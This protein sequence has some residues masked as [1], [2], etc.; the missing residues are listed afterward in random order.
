LAY[1]NTGSQGSLWVAIMEKAYAFFRTGAGT[2]ASI[3]AGWMSEVYSALGKTSTSYFSVASGT[4]LLN[5][6]K[7]ALEQ[8]KSVTLGVKTPTDG[9]PLIGDHAYMVDHVNVDNT[10][11]AVS[12]TLRNPW[13]IDGAGNDGLNDGYVT[14]TAA[15][16]KNAFLGMMI[17]AV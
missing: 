11:N 13:G 6:M 3:E 7:A 9:A 8:G 10:G 15:Q 2:Y 17:A 4:E 16:A 14:V 5:T 12:V 1:A